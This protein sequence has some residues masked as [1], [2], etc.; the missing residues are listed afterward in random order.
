MAQL[1][2][3]QVAVTEGSER[4]S[5]FWL[6][7]VAALLQLACV[8]AYVVIGVALGPEPV[9]VVEHYALMAQNAAAGLLRDDLATLVL[10]ALYLG[11]FP[12]LYVA[13][14]RNSP[15]FAAL[16]TAF[17]FVGVTIA[18]ASHSTLSMLFLSQQYAGAATAAQRELYLAAGEAVIFSDLWHSSG[19]YLAG[20]LLQGS[21]MLISAIMLR[22][23]AFGKVTAASGLVA[24]GLDLIQHLIHLAMPGLAASILMLA[25]PFYLVWF[26]AL[27]WDFFRLARA[28][29]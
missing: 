14:R 25:G 1:A 13:L 26:I 7:G 18:L 28:E 22:S 21:G 11:T 4:R 10:I 8:A 5:L 12:G 27:G 9:T 6:S 16:A 29:A 15:I 20:I 17:T 24:N 23:A 2:L 3:P 19:G